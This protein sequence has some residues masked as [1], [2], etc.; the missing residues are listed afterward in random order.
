[1][2]ALI[3]ITEPDGAI[4]YTNR[5]TGKTALLVAGHR[6]ERWYALPGGAWD[7]AAHAHDTRHAAIAAIEEIL[8]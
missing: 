8:A 7:A 4:R 1:M 3:A 6:T 2:T 5:I